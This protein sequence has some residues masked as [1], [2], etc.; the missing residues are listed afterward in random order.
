MEIPAK[1]RAELPPEIAKWPRQVILRML[2]IAHL[3]ALFLSGLSNSGQNAIWFTDNDDFAA[4]DDRVIRLTPL[5]AG[6]VS[7]S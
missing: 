4:N 2:F 5:F 6:I 3:G 7:R 1:D